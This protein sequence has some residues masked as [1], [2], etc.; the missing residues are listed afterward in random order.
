MSSSNRSSC[1][2]T[3]TPS[4][5]ASYDLREQ[6]VKACALGTISTW[7]SQDTIDY[8]SMVSPE[9]RGERQEAKSRYGA[10]S[11]RKNTVSDK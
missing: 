9:S 7:P 6:G 5:R 2:G 11:T 1:C 3:S 10:V 8:C 4:L